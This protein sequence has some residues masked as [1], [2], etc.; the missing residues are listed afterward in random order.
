[1]LSPCLLT[2]QIRPTD[3]DSE[4][5]PCSK[6]GPKQQKASCS[7]LNL[8]RPGYELAGPQAA[9]QQWHF[10]PDHAGRALQ[11]NY[12]A[13]GENRA[14]S[15]SYSLP[16]TRLFLLSQFQVPRHF[17]SPPFSSSSTKRLGLKPK[18]QSILYSLLQW[19]QQ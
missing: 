4:Q 9:W 8:V 11:S 13:E 5:S 16:S 17:Y 15:I 2:I 18:I 10:I 7:L 14:L 19:A 1:M 6:N 3:A 12:S